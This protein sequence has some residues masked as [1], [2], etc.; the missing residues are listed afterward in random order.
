MKILGL[1]RRRIAAKI[2]FLSLWDGAVCNL[3]RVN[4]MMSAS[5]LLSI[6]K[7]KPGQ[8]LSPIIAMTCWLRGGFDR[9]GPPE[10]S[11]K[12]SCDLNFVQKTLALGDDGGALRPV[13]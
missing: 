12:R 13:F 10:C 5:H 4:S 6:G 1:S 7:T 8:A 2:C 9:V 11:P 3:R